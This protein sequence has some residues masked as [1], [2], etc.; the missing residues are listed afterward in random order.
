MALRLEERR[1]RILDLVGILMDKGPVSTASLGA[2]AMR[3]WA[4][5]RRTSQD[6]I[7][8]L[9]AMGYARLHAD[10]TISATAMGERAVLELPNRSS[11]P[12]IPASEA[13]LPPPPS[14]DGG[15]G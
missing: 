1:Q 12:K 11:A 8:D 7:D 6:Y 2:A 9:V 4:L 3:S 15:Q 10:G 5:T 14:T 13:P